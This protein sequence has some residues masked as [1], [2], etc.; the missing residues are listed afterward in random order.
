MNKFTSNLNKKVQLSV[1]FIEQL[2]SNQQLENIN[3][4]IQNLT[5]FAQN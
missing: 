5:G 3:F 4:Q 2:F 1:N